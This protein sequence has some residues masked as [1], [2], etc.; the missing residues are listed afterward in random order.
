MESNANTFVNGQNFTS[1]DLSLAYQYPDFASPD[2]LPQL[3]FT[4]C[5]KHMLR[6]ASGYQFDY[7]TA[8]IADLDYVSPI[9]PIPPRVPGPELQPFVEGHGIIIEVLKK[10][11]HVES[12]SIFCLLIVLIFI[13]IFIVCLRHCNKKSS[14]QISLPTI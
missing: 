12:P 11:H 4:P 14:P 6:G 3:P 7:S 8:P 13:V 2:M 9:I 1:Y 10:P 5:K